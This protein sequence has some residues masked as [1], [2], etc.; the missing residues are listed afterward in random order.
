MPNVR[1]TV[2]AT[3][4]FAALAV[5]IPAAASANSAG[6]AHKVTAKTEKQGMKV[7]KAVKILGQ[8]TGDPGHFS[9]LLSNGRIAM[10]PDHFERLTRAAMRRA[11]VKPNSL[12][13]EKTGSCGDSWITLNVKEDGYP[14]YRATGF[15]VDYEGLKMVDL[16]WTGTISGGAGTG[17]APYTYT[18]AP[19]NPPAAY[20]WQ[21]VTNSKDDYGFGTYKGD[22]SSTY[23]WIE[24][25]NYID[26][27]YSEGPSVD[28]P[29][30]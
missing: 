4:T 5:A 13:D 20:S 1:L 28:G 9:L 16:Y 21:N 30:P 26:Y 29:L 6:L 14:L 23:S 11:Q 22:V 18:F 2:I 8:T 12:H 19:T 25:S 24:L 15:T 3:A 10:V 7:A 17:Y 27:C